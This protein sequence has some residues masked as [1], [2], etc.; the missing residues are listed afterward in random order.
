M[1]YDS[2]SNPAESYGDVLT[3]VFNSLTLQLGSNDGRYEFDQIRYVELEPGVLAAVRG[4][5]YKVAIEEAVSRSV[6]KAA[7][8]ADQIAE[9]VLRSIDGTLPSRVVMAGELKGLTRSAN[10]EIRPRTG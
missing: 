8:N 2:E 7:S 3:P 6:I 10:G 9:L 4:F 5:A 1:F